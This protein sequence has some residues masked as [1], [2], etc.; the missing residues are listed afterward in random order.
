M[1]WHPYETGKTAPNTH[2]VPMSPP[3]PMVE[4]PCPTC[5]QCPT[6]GSSKRSEDRWPAQPTVIY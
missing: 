3:H 4:R 2:I 1:F 6:C 5:G